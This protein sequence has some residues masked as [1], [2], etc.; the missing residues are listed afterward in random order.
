MEEAQADDK[1]PSGGS[2][3]VR[4]I[5]RIA[6]HVDARTYLEVGV[7]KGRT[8]NALTFDRKVAVD[9]RFRFDIADHRKAGVDFH[10]LTSDRYF[11]EYG[12]LQKFDIVFLDG[13][14]TFQQTLRDF[15]NS[16]ACAHA[17]TVWL[18]DD[19]LPIDVFSAWPVQKEAYQFRK[20]AGGD[21]AAWHGDVFKVVFFIHDFF[22]MFRYVT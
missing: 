18:I 12:A 1:K 16:L 19:V 2:H 6:E 9:P 10:E 20:R 3:S 5:R 7:A 8:F 15:C 14:H 21:S 11:S 13:L 17:R 4:R 22:P